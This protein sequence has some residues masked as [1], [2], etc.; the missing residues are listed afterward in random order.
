MLNLIII[1]L[2]ILFVLAAIVLVVVILL[3][4][5]R[6]GGFGAALGT[7]GQETFGVG[8]RGINTFTATTAAV[9]LGSALLIHVLN[10]A[11]GGSS[12]VGDG[13]GSSVLEGFDPGGGVP[14]PPAQPPQNP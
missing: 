11:Q 5:G 8:T 9:F 4:E 1:L 7:S 6:G 2:Y 3:Q 10:R 12:V 13:A 14:L